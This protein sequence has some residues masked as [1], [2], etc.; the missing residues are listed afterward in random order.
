MYPAEYLVEKLQSAVY[1]LVSGEGD[2][3]SRVREA[4]YKFWTIKED[5]FPAHLRDKRSEIDRLLTRLPG[6]DGYIIP[7]NL[8]KMKNKTASK[9]ACL[10]YE[11]W[12]EMSEYVS[13]KDTQY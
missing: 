8:S 5:N 10:I 3:R 12:F 1:D 13:A 6:R 9:I 2:A 11:L 7:D 4:Y